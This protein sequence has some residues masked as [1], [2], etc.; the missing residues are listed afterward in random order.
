[1]AK[2]FVFT[3]NRL[4]MPRVVSSYVSSTVKEPFRHGGEG[5]RHHRVRG[6]LLFSYVIVP[7]LVTSAMRAYL[8]AA[9]HGVVLYYI[10]LDLHA[11]YLL[12]STCVRMAMQSKPTLE[13]LMCLYCHPV[14][15]HSLVLTTTITRMP[16]LIH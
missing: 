6:L 11:P 16:I 7:A 5:H 13:P 2:V 14:L 1:M 3:L 12:P 15:S 8:D 10:L 4:F 9:G